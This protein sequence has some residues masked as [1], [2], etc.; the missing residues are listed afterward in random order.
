MP[1]R[2][3]WRAPWSEPDQDRLDGGQMMLLAAIVM[4]VGFVA[5]SGM[6]A[7]V[8]QLSGETVREQEDPVIVEM[9]VV[10]NGIRI[11]SNSTAAAHPDCTATTNKT[12]ADAMAHL[13]FV[14][15]SRGFF[16]QYETPVCTDLGPATDRISVTYALTD[17]LTRVQL[18]INTT[19]QN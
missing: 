19:A 11:V 8:A 15:S 14:E 7:R 17:G 18:R 9:D 1:R 6:L 3:R 2:E 5:L 16:M 13:R 10:A 12:L 4:V